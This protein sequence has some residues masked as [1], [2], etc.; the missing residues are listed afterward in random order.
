MAD[1]PYSN[2]H[3]F[4]RGLNPF[5]KR[6][7]RPRR[8]GKVGRPEMKIFRMFLKAKRA[9]ASNVIPSQFLNEFLRD[10]IVWFY[11][12]ARLRFWKNRAS[13][14]K[15]I[16]GNGLDEVQNGFVIDPG[17]P[18]TSP[19]FL[20]ASIGPANWPL[21]QRKSKRRKCLMLSDRSVRRAME[22]LESSNPAQRLASGLAKAQSRLFIF[23]TAKQPQNKF[24]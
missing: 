6:N 21:A 5:P 23:T 7:L 10:R 14:S 16:M 8:G 20:S 19:S 12:F 3:P 24:R 11:F 2:T 13:E 1:G 17:R 18:M 9:G 22:V 4:W 15:E